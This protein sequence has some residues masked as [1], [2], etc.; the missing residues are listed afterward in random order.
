MLLIKVIKSDV[1]P[2]I[3]VSFVPKSRYQFY[4]EFE[5]N[6]LFAIPVFQ[7]TV[8]LNPEFKQYFSAE[9]M[10]QLQLLELDPATLARPN[11]SKGKDLLSLEEVSV[12]VNVP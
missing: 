10:A 8:Q 1:V 12:S 7:F 11:E 5:F 9:D 6:G 4:I 2:D 3:R